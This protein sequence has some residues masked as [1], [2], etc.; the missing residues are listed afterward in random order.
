LKQKIDYRLQKPNEATEEDNVSGKKPLKILF[1]SGSGIGLLIQYELQEEHHPE[2]RVVSVEYPEECERLLLE[3]NYD[4]LITG[5]RIKN[6]GEAGLELTRF[7]KEN[8]P[9]TKVLMMSSWTN[10][11]EALAAGAD[12]YWVGSNILELIGFIGEMFL[13]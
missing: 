8:C 3:G 1:I 2:D 7:A 9:G 13:T 12:G 5:G 10:E 6:R 11:A 4:L